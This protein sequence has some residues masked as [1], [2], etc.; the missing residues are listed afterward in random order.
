MK[1]KR[2]VRQPNSTHDKNDR[3]AQ[4]KQK[5]AEIDHTVASAVADTCSK[6]L[7]KHVSCTGQLRLAN[8]NQALSLGRLSTLLGKDSQGKMYTSLGKVLLGQD[9]V[10]EWAVS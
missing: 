6:Q 3:T 2:N 1:E 5:S 10:S 4:A 7:V 9:W 8:H